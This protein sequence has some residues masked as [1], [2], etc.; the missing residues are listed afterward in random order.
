MLL[1][2]AFIPVPFPRFSAKYASNP[3]QSL[4]NAR[5][6]RDAAKGHYVLLDSS[7]A[8]AVRHHECGW[9]HDKPL[10]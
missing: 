4:V 3:A 1:D 8:S 9:L 5:L 10:S 7:A 2:P 6:A